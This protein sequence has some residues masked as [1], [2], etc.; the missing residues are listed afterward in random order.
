M[1]PGVSNTASVHQLPTTLSLS[2]RGAAKEAR[3]R[4]SE[5]AGTLARAEVV[6]ARGGGVPTPYQRSRGTSVARQ[7]ANQTSRGGTPSEM[8]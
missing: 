2:T 6:Y 5:R 3:R 1:R 8:A 4:S 7:S